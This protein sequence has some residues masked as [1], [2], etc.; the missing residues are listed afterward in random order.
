[1]VTG[2]AATPEVL[3]VVLSHYGVPLNQVQVSLIDPS[4]IA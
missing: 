2:N 4:H 3:D 1:V